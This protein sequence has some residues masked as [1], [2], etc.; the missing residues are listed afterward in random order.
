MHDGWI[1]WMLALYSNMVALNRPLIQYRLHSSQHA[2]IRSSSL[3]NRIR[4]SVG[5]TGG[6][7][8]LREVS[9]FEALLARMEERSSPSVAPWKSLVNARLNL[10]HRRLGLSESAP[11]RVFQVLSLWTDYRKLTEGALTMARDVMFP[12]RLA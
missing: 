4:K 5:Q 9:Q 12:H 11:V 1:A 10:L 2:S 8:L 3:R 7:T 6:E